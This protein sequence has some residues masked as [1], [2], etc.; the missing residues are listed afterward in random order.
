MRRGGGGVLVFH[1]QISILTDGF[2][3]VCYVTR[4]PESPE[5]A[6]GQGQGQCILWSIYLLCAESQLHSPQFDADLH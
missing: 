1:F 2:G 4:Q 5:P 3:G 6:Q